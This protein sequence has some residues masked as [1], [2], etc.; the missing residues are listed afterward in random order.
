M[1]H[2][3]LQIKQQSMNYRH[4]L[5][6]KE[7]KGYNKFHIYFTTVCLGWFLRVINQALFRFVKISKEVLKLIIP[8]SV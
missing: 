7:G 5:Q 8:N 2:G 4:Q 6:Q 1:R 3:E